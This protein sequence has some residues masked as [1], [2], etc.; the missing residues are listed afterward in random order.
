MDKVDYQSVTGEC[1]MSENR[2]QIVREAIRNQTEPL[3]KGLGKM[4]RQ[5]HIQLSH[6]NDRLIKTEAMTRFVAQ[7]G[8]PAKG[9]AHGAELR[10]T[11]ID[12]AVGMPKSGKDWSSVAH[13]AMSSG[14]DQKWACKKQEGFESLGE[15]LRK[16]NVLFHAGRHDFRSPSLPVHRS[17]MKTQFEGK[18]Q[19]ATKGY[20]DSLGKELRTSSI[21]LSDLNKS[22]SDWASSSQ[23][24][25]NS[26]ADKKWTVKQPGGFFHLKKELQK[27]NV[28]LGS[29][30]SVY[31]TEGHLKPIKDD[32]KARPA[33]ARPQV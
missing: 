26:H 16:S 2:D 19:A 27:T 15:E 28:T 11:H 31:G 4:L 25:L 7:R 20:A 3:S 9:F 23:S 21:A 33:G 29:D 8:S 1:F 10:S 13:T 18:P 22:T 30:T 6:Q 24:M 12:L 14:E 5:S 32:R 17:E